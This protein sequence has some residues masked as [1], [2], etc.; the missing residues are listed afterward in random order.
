MPSHTY[1]MNYNKGTEF[2]QS[3]QIYVLLKFNF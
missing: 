1:S 2:Q 3:Y